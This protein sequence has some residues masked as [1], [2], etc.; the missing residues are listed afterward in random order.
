M[1]KKQ[2]VAGTLNML[3]REGMGCAVPADSKKTDWY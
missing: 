3:E 2:L 1:I